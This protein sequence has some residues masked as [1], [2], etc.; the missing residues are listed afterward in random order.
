MEKPFG[1][2]AVPLI[3]NSIYTPYI[4]GLYWVYFQGHHHFPYEYLTISEQPP[5][6]RVMVVKDRVKGAEC[7]SA[8]HDVTPEFTT[9]SYNIDVSISRKK[10]QEGNHTG[11]FIKPR[12]ISPDTMCN[13]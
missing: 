7:S 6:P 8:N 5:R 12:I 13:A 10:L 11:F 2:G 3:I 1:M 9:T 4:A